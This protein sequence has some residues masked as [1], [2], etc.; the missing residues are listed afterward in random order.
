[1]VQAQQQH[2]QSHRRAFS[3]ATG[4]SFFPSSQIPTIGGQSSALG[5]AMR[6]PPGA[7]NVSG[8]GLSAL[9]TEALS[10]SPDTHT[11]PI[12]TASQVEEEGPEATLE[13]RLDS[14]ESRQKRI[15]DMLV[16]LVA[17]VRRKK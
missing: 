16:D 11:E 3:T 12:E 2:Q 1:M 8:G 17:N 7:R 5:L 10:E 6:R 9:A 13:K 14:M 4:D 15:E